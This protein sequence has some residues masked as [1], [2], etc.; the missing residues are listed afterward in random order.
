MFIAIMKVMALV[1]VSLS[2]AIIDGRKHN[3]RYDGFKQVMDED[4]RPLNE[5][6][7]IDTAE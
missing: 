7:L 5:W 1:V 2:F 4:G 3:K 6:I